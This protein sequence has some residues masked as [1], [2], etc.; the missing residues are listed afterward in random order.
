VPGGL[1]GI[2]LTDFHG[3]ASTIIDATPAGVFTA[4]TAIDRLPEWNQRIAAVI[5]TPGTPLTEGTE[6]TVQMH[7]P[8]ATWPS[9]SRVLTF[10]PVRLLFEYTSQ[11]DDGNPSYV[12]WRWSIVSHGDSA[13]VT[14]GWTGYPKTFWRRLVFARLRRKQLRA[15]A[16]A[17]LRALARHLT[18]S[19][20]VR[21]PG[22]RR[23]NV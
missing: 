6:W 21:L 7:V 9:R 22:R 23:S 10:D 20:A 12:I 1:S 16:P 4:I 14:V 11:S 3:Q 8:P 18:P 2:L 15:E 17:S 13:R 19:Q 5:R